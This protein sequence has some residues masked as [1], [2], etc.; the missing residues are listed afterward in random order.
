MI[1]L[2]DKYREN[3]HYSIFKIFK[4]LMNKASSGKSKCYFKN[5][6]LDFD[7]ISSSFLKELY[8]FKN[9]EIIII[10]WDINKKYKNIFCKLLI[11]AYKK[12]I[13]KS[14]DST[15]WV[16]ERLKDAAKRG[17]V[18]YYI[19]EDMIEIDCIEKIQKE[20]LDIK[21]RHVE[22]NTTGLRY[23]EFYGWVDEKFDYFNEYE[24]RFEKYTTVDE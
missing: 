11:K 5:E 3:N 10:S 4:I 8:I 16:V 21:I 14:K 2:S 6:T 13:I 7:K 23:Y 17:D 24:K 19:I 20:I 12:N 1:R 15:K 22:R 18:L 9:S